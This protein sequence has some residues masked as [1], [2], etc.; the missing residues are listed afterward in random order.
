MDSPRD[1]DLTPCRG[2][3]PAGRLNRNLLAPREGMWP[4]GAPSLFLP[5]SSG[6]L[7]ISTIEL[8]QTRGRPAA[9]AQIDP[10]SLGKLWAGGG[11]G[12][13]GQDVPLP[14][15]TGTSATSRKLSG[16][17][18]PSRKIKVW[19]PEPESVPGSGGGGPQQV[20]G[21][22]R[23]TPILSVPGLPLGGV[24]KGSLWSHQSQGL[25]S[26]AGGGEDWGAPPTP[27]GC[28]LHGF[29]LPKPTP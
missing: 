2:C 28:A 27:Q 10:G 1:G 12:W 15:P 25:E 8:S 4:P 23:P 19:L 16:L 20:L 21:C 13:M 17:S 14:C 9:Q 22:P 3:G 11:V 29:N 24:K 18:I 26:P 5:I 6:L 7:V